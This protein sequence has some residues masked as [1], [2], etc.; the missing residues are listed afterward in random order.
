L[1]FRADSSEILKFDFG[2]RFFT[3]VE[4]ASASRSATYSTD[5]QNGERDHKRPH[6]LELRDSFFQQYHISQAA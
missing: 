5:E 2:F 6:A 4:R 1:A 3:G